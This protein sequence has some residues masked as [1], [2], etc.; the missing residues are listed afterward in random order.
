MSGVAGPGFDGLMPANGRPTLPKAPSGINGLDEVTG[1]GLPRGRPTLVCGAAGCGKTLLAMEF[2]VRGIENGEPGV[3]VS[4]EET[5]DELATNFAS[6]AF[7]LRALARTKKLVVDYV[8]VE[9]HQIE[10]TGEYDLEGLFIRLGSAIDEIGAK[11]VVMDSVET[12][13]SGL[14]N[15]GILRAELKRL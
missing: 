1:G 6:L 4:F 11:R 3:F 10:E 5:F 2:L 12:L 13:F 15:A 9:R 7:D 8:S 14:S